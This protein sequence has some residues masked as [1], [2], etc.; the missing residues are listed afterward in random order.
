MDTWEAGGHD[1]K[2]FVSPTTTHHTPHTTQSKQSLVPNTVFCQLQY[3]HS[4]VFLNPSK[5]MASTTRTMLLLLGATMAL[6]IVG[7]AMA[8]QDTKH[9]RAEGLQRLLTENACTSGAYGSGIPCGASTDCSSGTC[10]RGNR[11]VTSAGTG[12]C[13]LACGTAST[14]VAVGDGCSCCSGSTDGSNSFGWTKCV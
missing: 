1:S 10:S 7:T 3:R 11:D 4:L 9:L 6:L 8:V 2:T 13:A 5:T 14:N 12:S